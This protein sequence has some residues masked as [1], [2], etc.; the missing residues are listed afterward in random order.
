MQFRNVVRFFAHFAKQLF[1]MTDVSLCSGWRRGLMQRQDRVFSN[2]KEVVPSAMCWRIYIFV[3]AGIKYD[4]PTRAYYH[5]QRDSTTARWAWLCNHPWESPRGS[6]KQ[7]SAQV[8]YL[9][10]RC[11]LFVH[12]SAWKFTPIG[13]I[14][15][16]YESFTYDDCRW[17]ENDKIVRSVLRLRS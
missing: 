10:S 13:C 15:L 16:L 17:W 1:A 11:C 12:L 5:R 9:F 8:K 2:L 6:C 14:D 4:P 7:S 3:F